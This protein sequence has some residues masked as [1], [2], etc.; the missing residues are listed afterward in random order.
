MAVYFTS[1]THFGHVNVIDYCHRP[2]TVS[3][4]ECALC[5]GSGYRTTFSRVQGEMIIPCKHPDVEKMDETIIK[6]WNER[7][8]PKDRVYHLGDF[9]MPGNVKHIRSYRERL[10]GGIVLVLGNHDRRKPAQYQDLGFEVLKSCLVGQLQMMHHPP[11][12]V[13]AKDGVTL[14]G[15]VHDMWAEKT[16][17][18]RPAVRIVNVGVDVRGFRPVTIE[19]LGLDPNLL[20]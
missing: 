18:T 7:V 12:Y 9:A 3:I 5:N 10:N 8:G 15:H 19:E 2:F 11:T 4:G 6:N 17:V 13:E 16:F 14:C 20:T 1:D